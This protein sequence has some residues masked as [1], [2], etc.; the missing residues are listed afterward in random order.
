MQLANRKQARYTKKGRALFHIVIAYLAGRK[1]HRQTNMSWKLSSL[2]ASAVWFFCTLIESC[3]K[4]LDEAA[5]A[6]AQKVQAE[7]PQTQC[8]RL[9]LKNEFY[10]FFSCKKR[11]IC[12]QDDAHTFLER[13]YA[14]LYTLQAFLCFPTFRCSSCAMESV[15]RCLFSG[16]WVA[17]SNGS[18][19]WNSWKADTFHRFTILQSLK[20]YFRRGESPQINMKITL[21][22]KMIWNIV[23]KHW[24]KESATKTAKNMAENLTFLDPLSFSR[25]IKCHPFWWIKVDANS[26]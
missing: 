5:A 18:T 21:P 24:L 22:T 17:A 13:T 14:T 6:E 3:W 26:W 1:K 9:L 11:P 25:V 12:A 15:V 19:S 7:H 10:C 16:L 2:T 23:S 4:V 8:N 20:S